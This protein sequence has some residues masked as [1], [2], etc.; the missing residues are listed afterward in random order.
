MTV[1]YNKTPRCGCVCVFRCHNEKWPESENLGKVS[2]THSQT[3]KQ[4]ERSKCNFLLHTCAFFAST[5]PS[6]AGVKQLTPDYWLPGVLI[7]L[8]LHDLICTVRGWKRVCVC[9]LFVL[10]PYLYIFTLVDLIHWVRL[11]FSQEDNT[12]FC[13]SIIRLLQGYRWLTAS[14]GSA[15]IQEDS[16]K[17]SAW[18]GTS[19]SLCSQSCVFSQSPLRT[20]PQ[21]KQ[22]WLCQTQTVYH[23]CFLTYITFYFTINLCHKSESQQQQQQHAAETEGQQRVDPGGLRLP[24]FPPWVAGLNYSAKWSDATKLTVLS[25]LVL[26]FSWIYWLM[27]T[28]AKFY[29]QGKRRDSDK[30]EE[31]YAGSPLQVLLNVVNS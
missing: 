28:P 11:K 17:L 3:V 29:V 19:C 23:I 24:V 7:K 18:L 8:I 26:G 15:K 4:R 14:A 10:V 31:C 20:G 6:T 5:R 30:L 13:T 27:E 1:I 21:S 9:S 2:R 22:R 16:C 12:S 25:W